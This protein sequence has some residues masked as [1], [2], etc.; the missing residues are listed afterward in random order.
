MAASST[1]VREWLAENPEAM[2]AIGLEEVPLRG[3]LPKG[4]RD[5]Y[6]QAHPPAT[7]AATE[8]PPP[9]P[10]A[11]QDVTAAGEQPPRTRRGRK[12]AKSRLESFWKGRGGGDKPKH[13]KPP[14]STLQDFAEDLWG[15]L[16][17]FAGP[18]KPVQRMLLAQAPYAGVM[19]EDTVKGTVVDAALQPIARNAG[20]LRAVNGI[21]GPP[22]FTAGIALTGQRDVK[23]GEPDARTKAM[24]LGLRYSLMQMS[25]V[26]GK[27]LAAVQEASEER[28]ARG[29]QIDAFMDWLFDM[30]PAPPDGTGQ[31]PDVSTEEDAIRRAQTMLGGPPPAG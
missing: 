31:H 11:G 22:I 4:A 30:R 29:D 18:V 15:D 9:G 12:A 13:R 10:D 26:S 7:T 3:P 25:K 2:Q 17:Y 16:A 21:F 20:A 23:T 27:Q 19:L 6:D 24:F 28:I 8:P 5:V 14:R 1:D